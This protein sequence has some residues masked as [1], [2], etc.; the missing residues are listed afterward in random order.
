MNDGPEYDHVNRKL[1]TLQECALHRR[2]V[3]I[4]CPQ[5]Q[6]VRRF[7]A[8]ALWWLFARKSWDDGVPGAVA[9]LYC[10]RCKNSGRVVRPRHL[11]TRNRPDAHQPPYP[12]E[13]TWK[14]LVARFRS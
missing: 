8:V 5:C 7:D 10:E 2:T 6:H 4:T 14:K 1:R 9:R 11:I 3:E 13:S 12:D